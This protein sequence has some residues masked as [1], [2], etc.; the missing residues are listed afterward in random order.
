LEYYVFNIV[1]YVYKKIH[2]Y[3]NRYNNEG[4]FNDYDSLFGKENNKSL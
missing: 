2:F 4:I 1:Q 3:L